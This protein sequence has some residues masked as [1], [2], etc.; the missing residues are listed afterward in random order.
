MG[1]SVV[2]VVNEEILEHGM[3]LDVTVRSGFLTACQPKC[4]EL[5]EGEM[6]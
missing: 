6:Q 3:L 2:E 1:R 5:L 4:S